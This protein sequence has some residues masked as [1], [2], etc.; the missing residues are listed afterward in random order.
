MADDL[1]ITPEQGEA[2]T[3]HLAACSACGKEFNRVMGLNE[4]GSLTQEYEARIRD[5]PPV[6][7]AE[8]DALADLWKR[9]NS[10]E[11]DQRRD[12][13]R[14]LFFPTA[15]VAA[16]VAIVLGGW[17][18]L[19]GRSKSISPAPTQGYA[20]TNP[21]TVPIQHGARNDKLQHDTLVNG[22]AEIDTASLSQDAWRQP[23]PPEVDTLDYVKWRDEHPRMASAFNL[24]QAGGKDPAGH[25]DYIES[26]MV[27]GDIWQ[28]HY[29]P[30]LPASQP[31]TK[32]DS[33]SI[34]TLPAGSP[35]PGQQYAEALRR[36]HDALATSG[37]ETGESTGDLM[38]FSL[39]ASQYLAETRTAAYLW[40]KTHP[41]E[42]GRLLAD[43]RYRAMVP[44]VC[45]TTDAAG[46]L[47]QLRQ[48]AIASRSCGKIALEWFAMPEGN[49]CTPQSA[50]NRQQLAAQVSE[51][52]VNESVS[53][54]RQRGG[55][56]Q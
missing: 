21:Q 13:Y 4:D 37:R 47:E 43:N 53:P 34:A 48:Q 49:G 40:V 22:Q 38:F 2:Y 3:C 19:G 30:K 27:S 52:V 1:T 14:T 24:Q 12:H 35:T 9:I 41:T 15:K 26:L 31:L 46:W 16:C 6:A 8:E 39:R 50:Q 51:L 36:W 55:E 18:V 25:V 17:F 44:M 54:S 20:K 56:R 45:A 10:R 11:A 28:F 42:A 33:A 7:M 29:D 32:S 5:L 23:E